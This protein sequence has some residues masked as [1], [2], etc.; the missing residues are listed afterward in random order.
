M[1]LPYSRKPW[2][3]LSLTLAAMG[4]TDGM[5]KNQG[6]LVIWTVIGKKV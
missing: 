1:V 2:S 5:G 3:V 6:I 4:N